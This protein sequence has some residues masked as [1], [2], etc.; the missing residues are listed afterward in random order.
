VRV[1]CDRVELKPRIQA[2]LA[3]RK[4]HKLS[5]R[6]KLALSIAGASALLLPIGIGMLNAPRVQAQPATVTTASKFEVASIR[7]CKPGV[8]TGQD[9]SPG[10]LSYGCTPLVDV[11]NIGLIQLAY[12]RFAGGHSNP[13]RVLTIEG[14]PKW[15]H[16][17]FF[18]IDAKAEGHPSVAM[19]Q[20]PM[21]Q[22]LLEDRFKLKIH[23][24][25]RQGPV[26]EL[27]PAKSVSKLKPFQE[28]SCVPSAPPFPP[29]PPGQAY[30]H[31]VVSPGSVNAEGRG[32]TDLSGLL[33]LIL[34][35]PV[36]DKTGI[37]GKFDIHLRFSPNELAARPQ[38]PPPDTPDAAADP[39]GPTV[40]TA[41][42]EQLGLRLVPAK[43]PI[44]VLVI[45]RVE[46]P[47]EN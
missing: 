22:A 3:N 24:E 14:G 11:N 38:E 25:T 21:L 40:F 35:R 26:Y 45:D 13:F 37:T 18:Q 15:I 9:S 36:L 5:F 10:R 20:G 46:R 30:C 29:L 19:M 7:P 32:L 43:G 1:R 17:E 27:T 8:S 23:R 31:E 28:G 41:I 6:K 47:S 16:S 2:I 12:V 33:S 39:N 44:D 34:D 42:Q 4:I